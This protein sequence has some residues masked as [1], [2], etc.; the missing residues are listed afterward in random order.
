M[1]RPDS[2]SSIINTCQRMRLNG[3]NL[4]ALQCVQCIGTGILLTPR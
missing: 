3:D 1:K 4:S 2:D